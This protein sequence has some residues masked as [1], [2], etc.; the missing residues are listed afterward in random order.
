MLD[1]FALAFVGYKYGGGKGG[2]NNCHFIAAYQT[3]LRIFRPGLPRPNR[4]SFATLGWDSTSASSVEWFDWSQE[5]G[6]QP[7]DYGKQ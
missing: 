7:R 4:A 3:P 6:L 2:L 1:S 5:K